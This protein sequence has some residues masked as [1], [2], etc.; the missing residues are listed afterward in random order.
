MEQIMEQME[1]MEQSNDEI[2]HGTCQIIRQKC[3]RHNALR[4]RT[5]SS[6]YP[7]HPVL[8]DYYLDLGGMDYHTLSYHL[9]YLSYRSG[10]H[11]DR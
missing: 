2:K 1:E 10:A 9:S 5:T 6:I 8:G 3:G 4:P 11:E 7:M